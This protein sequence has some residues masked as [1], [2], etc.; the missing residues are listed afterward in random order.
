MS[1]PETSSPVP[2]YPSIA[3]ATLLQGHMP[4]M[5]A[6]TYGFYLRQHRAHGDSLRFRAYP[7]V[8][9]YSFASAE[10]MHHILIKGRQKYS[11]GRRWSNIVSYIGGNGIVTSMGEVWKRQRQTMTP[12]FQ[13]AQVERYASRVV[14]NALDLVSKGQQLAQ[15]TEINVSRAMMT[16]G[17]INISDILFDYDIRSDAVAFSEAMMDGFFFINRF[18]Q[19]PLTPPRF[20]PLPIN[21]RFKRNKALADEVVRKIIAAARK[22][23]EDCMIGALVRSGNSDRQLH[24]EI[25]TLLMAGHDTLSTALSWAWYLLARHPEVLKKVQ[26]ELDAELQGQPPT[27]ESIERLTYT[28]MVFK[29]TLRL[30][31]SAWAIHR[32]AEEADEVCGHPVRRGSS[33]VLPVYVTHRHPAYWKHPDAFYPEHFAKEEADSRPRFAYAPFGAGEHVCIGAHLAQFE[34][35]LIMATILQKFT[36]MLKDNAPVS[37]VVNFTLK[38]ERDIIGIAVRR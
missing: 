33:V 34:G 4:E 13:P 14:Q 32:L 19:N 8:N 20:L 27:A 23:S 29:E 28:K 11:R 35:V 17:L 25:I 2:A 18:I 37:P 10:A 7:G 22:D 3:G 38:P 1:Q 9:F 16:L 26:A 36:P 24:D 21:Q 15:G 12:S 6:D 5:Q 31:P 30:Y